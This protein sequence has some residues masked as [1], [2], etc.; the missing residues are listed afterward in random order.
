MAHRHRTLVM[1]AYGLEVFGVLLAGCGTTHRLTSAPAAPTVDEGYA[2]YRA[3]QATDQ[4][5]IVARATTD[6]ILTAR[7]Q[8]TRA[9]T[10][11]PSFDQTLGELKQS[12]DVALAAYDSRRRTFGQSGEGVIGA[13]RDQFDLLATLPATEWARQ[14]K[15]L[16]PQAAPQVVN[17]EGGV[18]DRLAEDVLVAT[19]ERSLCVDTSSTGNQ[20]QSYLG[21]AQRDVEQLRTYID[22]LWWFYHAAPVTDPVARQWLVRCANDEGSIELI[23]GNWGSARANCL[24]ALATGDPTLVAMMLETVRDG[25]APSCEQQI[26]TAILSRSAAPRYHSAPSPTCLTWC[27]WLLADPASTDP[28][29]V[30]PAQACQRYQNLAP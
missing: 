2:T 15:M 24:R 18:F 10:P 5:T 13:C 8:A 3:V 14:W 28:A 20:A 9:A 7:A 29:L 19:G 30:R 25:P 1:A 27:G 12:V 17:D 21:R 23:L 6:V 22:H 4:A 26:N 16:Y 11:T